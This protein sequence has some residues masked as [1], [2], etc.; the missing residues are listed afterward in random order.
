MMPTPQGVAEVIEAFVSAR[1]NRR[2]RRCRASACASPR[3]GPARSPT[4]P[5]AAAPRSGGCG[6]SAATGPTSG[7]CGASG[8]DGAHRP[9][10]PGRHAAH[11]SA[12]RGR[13]RR[14][15]GPGR[16]QAHPA[17]RQ[18]A[19]RAEA[20]LPPLLRVPEHREG[21]SL[22]AAL[23]RPAGAGLACRQ[24]GVI[25][26]EWD[27]QRHPGPGGLRA[28]H[29]RHLS[30]AAQP[31]RGLPAQAPAR[32]PARCRAAAAISGNCSPPCIDATGFCFSAWS[33]ARATRGASSSTRRRTAAT[34]PSRRGRSSASSRWASSAG[35]HWPAPAAAAR[36][37][38][39]T[40]SL[41]PEP[42][43]PW[44]HE[45]C[46]AGRPWLSA[47]VTVHAVL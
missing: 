15:H 33:S 1:R 36:C 30:R 12:R 41:G 44:W 28:R 25:A 42:P 13:P 40:A 8:V 45:G 7:R 24:V 20:W 37:S 3:P 10:G 5:A 46:L 31:G 9:R 14:A 19:R 38:P 2:R 4:P 29:R 26:A 35:I 17:Q 32:G 22:R 27:A 34:T 18:G 11:L 23:R 6:C 43:S 47:G 21:R 39:T 16:A